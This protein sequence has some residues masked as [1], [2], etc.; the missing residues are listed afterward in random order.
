[1]EITDNNTPEL[2]NSSV[3]TVGEQ[4]TLQGQIT[5]L[6]SIVK[7]MADEFQHMKETKT[8]SSEK[9]KID[10]SEEA[11]PSGLQGYKIPKRTHEM[12]DSEE[13]ETDQLNAEIDAVL[14]D[15]SDSAQTADPSQVDDMD[16]IIQLY[17]TDDAPGE[18]LVNDKLAN[19]V[20]KMIRNKLPEKQANEKMEQYKRPKNL[21]NLKVPQ[22]NPGI[23]RKLREVTIKKDRYA[24]HMQNALVKG[25][26][27]LARITDV[28]TTQNAVQG[29]DL[30]MLKKLAIDAMQ[31]FAEANYELNIQRKMS[32]R[33][34][35]GQQYA[36]LCSPQVA[37]TDWLFGDDLAKEMKEIGDQNRI[38]NK[39]TGNNYGGNNY[40]SKSNG[41]FPFKNGGGKKFAKHSSY[42]NG[43]SKNFHGRGKPFY[44]QRENKSKDNQ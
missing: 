15:G 40:G 25:M 29:E 5:K 17:E 37:V 18:P 23:Y 4:L 9:R 21:D 10:L 27:P 35:I 6:T 14:G 8:N 39:F 11:G 28:L 19:L 36:A 7:Q 38:G 20:N 42:Q 34:D 32:M 41:R 16:Q 12:S 44:K 33:N 26:I 1:M 30:Q 3:S 22:V 2:S 43:G 13:S 31:F 24:R